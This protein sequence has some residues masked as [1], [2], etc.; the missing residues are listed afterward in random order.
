[1]PARETSAPRNSRWCGEKPALD[2]AVPSGYGPTVFE[3]AGIGE[4]DPTAYE[5]MEPAKAAAPVDR[6]HAAAGLRGLRAGPGAFIAFTL[7]SV[8]RQPTDQAMA[9]KT[10]RTAKLAS[11]EA[12]RNRAYSSTLA[13]LGPLWQCGQHALVFRTSG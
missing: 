3:P 10:G 7:K 2:P 4:T 11:P 1:M 8:A 9:L 12:N 13:L 5:A 6:G